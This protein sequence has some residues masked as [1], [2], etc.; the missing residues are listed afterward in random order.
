MFYF[1]INDKKISTCLPRKFICA[2]M[3]DHKSGICGQHNVDLS[4]KRKDTKLSW[5]GGQGC[6]RKDLEGGVDYR[7]NSFYE[8][9]RE[10]I[11][12]KRRM[13]RY[14]RTLQQILF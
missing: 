14:E 12:N 2:P 9:H 13:K 4:K 8:I 11:K 3:E 5:K 10:L 6:F 1:V 7:Q